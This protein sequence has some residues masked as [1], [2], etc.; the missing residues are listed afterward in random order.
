MYS[1]ISKDSIY[2]GLTIS[3]ELTGGELHELKRWDFSFGSDQIM[4]HFS[5]LFALWGEFVSR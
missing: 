1:L 3:R 2:L 4:S 5:S